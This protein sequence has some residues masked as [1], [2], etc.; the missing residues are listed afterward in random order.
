[1]E[2]FF[3]LNWAI[4]LPTLGGALCR[5][6][7][8][9]KR[10]V[11]GKWGMENLLGCGLIGGCQH[12]LDFRL[13]SPLIGLPIDAN[14]SSIINPSSNTWQADV[15]KQAFSPDD[16]NTILGIPLSSRC[17]MD[18]LIWAYTSKGHFTVSSAYKVAFSSISNPS[19][20]GSN[21]QNCR[22]F[23]KSLWGLNIPNKVKNFAWQA[24]HNI[25]PTKANLCY[26]KILNN[27]TCK[28]CGLE[29]ETVTIYSG[30]APKLRRFGVSRVSHWTC[31]ESIFL[32]SLISCG[33]SSL[34]N[35]QAIKC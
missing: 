25:L 20:V 2:T 30:F 19:P 5:P 9:C 12:H 11:N 13:T 18:R 32:S 14:V 34:C 21:K 28:A 24:C 6:N 3:T 31:E 17:P 22:K 7:Q 26:W 1:M 33:T 29:T 35:M 16:A 4:I 15:M 27:P 23:W 10:V 8:L